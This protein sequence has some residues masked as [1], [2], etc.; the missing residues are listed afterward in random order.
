MG[1]KMRVLSLFDGMA[2]GLLSLKLLGIKV[3]EYHAF[4]ID[5]YAIQIAKKNH[6]EIIHHGTVVGANFKQFKNFDL[7]LAGSPCQGFSLSGKQLAFNDPRSKLYFEF[8]RAI[9]EVSPKWF[10]LENVKMKTEYRDVISSRLNV[11]PIQ[12]NSTLVSAQNR[13]RNYWCNWSVTQPIDR[14]IKLKD[15]LLDKVDDK[16]IIKSESHI[17]RFVTSSDIP[18]GFTRINPEKAVTMTAR[19]YANWKGTYI[20]QLP[21]GK[22]PSITPSSWEHNKHLLTKG[23]VR[24]LTPV[25]CERLQTLPDNYTNGVSDSQRYKMIGNGWNVATIVHILKQNKGLI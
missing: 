23:T 7:I 10:L 5:K 11:E 21:N 12:I 22:C 2:C 18:K 19:Q 24:K 1:R 6:S 8:E 17:K 25:E 16:Y 9:K 15:I 3:S 20:M 14:N 13:V 4:E